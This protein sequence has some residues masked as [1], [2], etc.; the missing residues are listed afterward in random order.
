[1]KFNIKEI[2]EKGWPMS[3]RKAVNELIRARNRPT[4]IG[5]GNVIIPKWEHGANEERITLPISSSGG[6]G[7]INPFH[8]ITRKNEDNTY[9]AAVYYGVV[10]NS[11]KPSLGV[12]DKLTITGLTLFTD[13]TPTWFPF[14]ATD[15][16]WL[17]IV[18]NNNAAINPTVTLNSYGKGD[19]FDYT[20]E[21]WSGE[22]GYCE[23]N[24]ETEGANAF[25]H[26]TS[27][28]ALAFFFPDDD[29]APQLSDAS[30]FKIEV[31]NVTTDLVLRNVCIEGRP[32]RYPFSK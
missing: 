28:I 30:E 10:Y 1:M 20:E 12:D 8:I 6:S 18:F 25:K 27:R 14:L 11:L 15:V 21:A 17:T 4:V 5:Y 29:G 31:Q 16:I 26:Q 7:A 3:L 24:G 2:S 9:S 22:N 32:A 23:D 19:S 13:E